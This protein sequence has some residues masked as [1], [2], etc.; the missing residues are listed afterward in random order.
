MFPALCALALAVLAAA[1][2]GLT[3]A[4]PLPDPGVVGGGVR[5]ALPEAGLR[6]VDPALRLAPLFAPGRTM[7]AAAGTGGDGVPPDWQLAGSI[8]VRGR[9]YAVML[10]P[11]GQVVR[12]PVGGSAGGMRLLS[13]SEEGAI[14]R[15]G[16]QRVA[17]VFGAAL[18]PPPEAAESDI[19]EQS[20]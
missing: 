17:M 16:G 6:P 2:L 10:A 3:G 14:F 20:E 15:Q 13:L 19:E 11:S 5:I 1:Q 7:A 9:G 4:E 12:V 8:T 18:V